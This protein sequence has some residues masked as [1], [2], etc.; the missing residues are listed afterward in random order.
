MFP[1][2]TEYEPIMPWSDG[3]TVD[4]RAQVYGATVP[5]DDE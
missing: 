4:L 5:V 2:V 1:N 3:P